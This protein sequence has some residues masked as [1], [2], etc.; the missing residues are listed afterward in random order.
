MSDPGSD[1]QARV[2]AAQELADRVRSTGQR[3]TV[4]ASGL[5]V[6]FHSTSDTNAQAIKESG[7]FKG[8]TWFAPSKAA[9]LLHAKPKHKKTATVEIAIDAREIEFSTG[10]G[11]F[12]APGGIKRGEA[13]QWHA[14]AAHTPDAV[15]TRRAKEAADLVDQLGKP[16]AGK[17]PGP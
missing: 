5:V 10:T 1:F 6:L 4:M 13:G 7:E 11:E 16:G 2:T 9:S 12:Y 17:T 14:T 8:N 3:L 15:T